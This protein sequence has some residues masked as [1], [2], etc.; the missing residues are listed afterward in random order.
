MIRKKR[1]PALA[2]FLSFLVPS[3][4]H[5]YMGRALRGL[6]IFAGANT[7]IL[8]S[9]HLGLFHKFS[10]FQSLQGFIIIVS[11]WFI[12]DSIRLARLH[13]HL[14]L[15][16]YNRWYVYTIVILLYVVFFTSFF[17]AKERLLGYRA[18][19]IESESMAPTLEKNDIVVS[20]TWSYRA[21]DP[22]RTDVILF[23]YPGNPSILY[24]KRVI[25]VGGEKVAIENGIVYINE[26]PL[27][28]PYVLPSARTNSYSLSMKERTMPDGELFV[29]GDCRD[30][31]KDSRYWGNVP[32]RNV[33][34]KVEFISMSCH[35]NRIGSSV[36]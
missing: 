25:A 7:L 17:G 36:Q 11:L 24:T 20:N 9:G 28:E 4:G 10:W 34:G 31:S 3:L 26:I 14:A 1:V 12:V 33:V 8:L 32:V 29:L 6:A 15:K 30:K 19:R 22:A 35:W 2:G 16:W 13:R 21:K 27:N 5:I 18:G 23:K